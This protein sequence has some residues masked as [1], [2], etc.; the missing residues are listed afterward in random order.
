MISKVVLARENMFRME[1]TLS[2]KV[3]KRPELPQSDVQLSFRL[4]T[5]LLDFLP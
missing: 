2:N 1:I 3:G 4:E 5:C